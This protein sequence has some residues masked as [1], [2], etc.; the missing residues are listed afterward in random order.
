[1]CGIAGIISPGNKNRDMEAMLKNMI[2]RGP[3]DCG[4][5]SDDMCNIMF[6]HRRLSILD[7]SSAGRQPMTSHDGRFSIACNGDI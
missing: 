5:W 3:D 2:H 4:T 7:L 1:M 6:G